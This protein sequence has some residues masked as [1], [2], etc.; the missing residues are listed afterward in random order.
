MSSTV[1]IKNK[2]IQ[3]SR[4][5]QT[6]LDCYYNENGAQKP[7]IIFC[8]G[9]K[10]F[11]DW[12][13]FDLMAE[14]FV[15]AGI[16]FIKFNF[17]FNGGTIENPIDFPDLEAFSENNY[18][19]ELNDLGEVIDLL[20]R[21]DLVSLEEMDDARVSLMGHSRG[22]GIVLLKT[23]EDS[24]IYKTVT[25]AAVADFGYFFKADPS[26]VEEC[27]KNGVIYIENSRTLQMMPIKYQFYEDYET[28]LSRLSILERVSKMPQEVLLFHGTKDSTVPMKSANALFEVIP[29]ARLKLMEGADHV[30]GAYQPYFENKLPEDFKQLIHHSILFLSEEKNVI[31][32]LESR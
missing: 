30:F 11:K 14:R 10:G 31:R 19:T 13:C 1:R 22:G 12:G 4:G 9:F 32:S 18:S 7:V 17:S 16:I 28:H 29:N 26:M 6:L 25:L 3:G 8:H 24:R 21:G 15:E 2:V 5:R 23:A 20:F 27:R